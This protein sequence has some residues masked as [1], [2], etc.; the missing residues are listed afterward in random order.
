L[1]LGLGMPPATGG[2][3]AF[4]RTQTEQ[5]RPTLTFAERTS[6]QYAIEEVYWRHRIWPP[7]GAENSGPKPALDVIV[8]ER[9][10]ERKVEDYLRKSQS[11]ADQ[12]GLPITASELQAEMDRM[13][14]HT[15]QPE[16]LREL[17][18][19]L[20]N[21][22]FVI[23]ECL[24][25]SALAERF[26]ADLT[27]VAGVPPAPSN[28]FAADTA[29][30]TGNRLGVTASLDNPQY[31]LP[32][33]SA[34]QDCAD[35]TW[36]ATSTVNAPDPREFHTAVWTGS[37]MIIW[38]GFNFSNPP[39]LNTGGRYYP[40]TDTW[41]ATSATNAPTGRDNHTAIWTGSEMI[42]W[43]GGNSAT[44]DLNTGGRYNPGA[45]SWTATSG[46]NAPDARSY[47]AAVWTGSEMIVWG[48]A[49]CGF[50]NCR[51]N[52]GGRYSPST[53]SWLPTSPTNAPVARFGH[54]AVWTGGE[55]IIWGGSDFI[56]N[57]TYLHTGAR[58]DPSTDN[59][60]PT[61][62]VNVAAG[63][64]GHTAVWTGSEMIVW[65]GVDETFNVTNTG[66]R[67]NPVNDSW[68]ATSLTNAP[69]PRTDQTGVW[70]GSEMIVWG[71]NDTIGD[72][73]TGGRYDADT[74]SWRATTTANALSARDGS[75]GVWTGS[76][77]IVWGG[78]DSNGPLGTG[79]RY[80]A[81]SGP[82]STP[83]PTPT[84]T[85]TAT[86]TSTSTPTPTATAT[87]GGS[88]SVTPTPGGSPAQALN[89]STRLRVLTD[90]NVGI[91][92]F[93]ITGTEPSAC[94]ELFCR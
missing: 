52:S 46:V 22:P 58:Y 11:V 59:W 34:P 89:L 65:G 41:M 18:A 50:N 37:E 4:A 93:I 57:H 15:R 78:G 56:N 62:I 10:I 23:A 40:A 24:A 21:D 92:G 13:A 60:T 64:V 43:G 44:G 7:S 76:Q 27:V 36:T 71:G 12:R 67:Y 61:S 48:G 77:M 73:N 33:I 70:T 6:Y 3:L 2:K 81:Q 5:L 85:A 32:E 75:T 54:S 20:G 28:S 38:G 63:R 69:S 17:F 83:T 1:L 14:Q 68:V 30:S 72:F 8:S 19:A 94:H 35:D 55:M 53:D 9:Q 25:R 31:K 87:A 82:T 74:D 16:V 39:T 91:G 80:C 84:A 66:G 79:G 51:L 26:S 29:A 49:G 90:A 88:P 42:V 45:D 86:P 47:H